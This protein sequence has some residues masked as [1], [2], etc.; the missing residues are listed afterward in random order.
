VLQLADMVDTFLVRNFF[1]RKEGIR[2]VKRDHTA[3]TT[4]TSHLYSYFIFLL[5]LN[6][7]NLSTSK[8]PLKELSS[9]QEPAVLEAPLYPTFAPPQSFP[10][11][12]PSI[13]Y[14]TPH[15]PYPLIETL[16][17][18]QTPVHKPLTLSLS[19]FQI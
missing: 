16:D 15:H 11:T 4:T 18:Y 17:S 14:A 7:V 2:P 1:A 13:P 19:S 3:N 8:C 12:M 10:R 6:I 5:L 9:L